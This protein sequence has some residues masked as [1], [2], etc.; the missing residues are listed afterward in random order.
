MIDRAKIAISYFEKGFN[1]AQSVLVAFSDLT[2]LNEQTALNV[3]GGYGSGCG[4]GELCGAVNGAIM[5][6]GLLN[7][8][9]KSE[10][11]KSKR[12]TMGLAK[13]LQN[14]FSERFDAVRC[15]DLLAKTA[16]YALDESTP[17]AMRLG[18]TKHCDIM[19][20]TA[21]DIVEEILRE[22]GK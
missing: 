16:G 5:A 6:L 11:V 4:T 21:V 1:C 18:L 9:D 3:S 17:S 13:E 15:R 20:A 14:R 10:P 2:G 19:V 8:I 12:Y 22:Q 7:P